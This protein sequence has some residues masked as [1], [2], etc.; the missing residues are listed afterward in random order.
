MQIFTDPCKNWITVY[1]KFLALRCDKIIKDRDPIFCS[2]VP[3]SSK[4]NFTVYL[5]NMLFLKYC[6]DQ[7]FILLF[8]NV[9]K[10]SK[11]L[12]NL[13]NKGHLWKQHHQISFKKVVK[14]LKTLLFW[15]AVFPIMALFYVSAG[16]NTIFSCPNERFS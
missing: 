11:D 15:T 16:Q 9:P 8:A 12:K 13:K 7:I 1:A 14:P 6:T 4:H 2:K 10:M 3:S 5:E